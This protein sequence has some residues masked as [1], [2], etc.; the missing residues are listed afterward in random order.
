MQVLEMGWRP[1]LPEHLPEDYKSFVRQCWEEDREK[2]GVLLAAAAVSC[3]S[4]SCSQVIG[5][6]E[7]CDDLPCTSA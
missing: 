2:V 1:E 3:V 4:L 7:P 6:Y 5:A